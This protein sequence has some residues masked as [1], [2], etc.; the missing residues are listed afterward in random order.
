MLPQHFTY[1]NGDRLS[2][3]SYVRP[4]YKFNEWISA[5]GV[6]YRDRAYASMMT[7]IDGAIVRLYADWVKA[8]Y[9][10]VYNSNGATSGVMPDKVATY[11][12]VVQLDP[13]RYSKDGYIFD[14]WSRS[15]DSILEYQ[16]EG[17]IGLKNEAYEN[18]FNLYARW[19]A[20]NSVVARLILHGERGTF[21]GASV[22]TY[23]LIN[24]QEINIEEPVYA[25]HRLTGWHLMGQAANTYTIP[26][27]CNFTG[28]IE[29]YADWEEENYEVIYHS[30]DGTNRVSTESGFTYDS[31]I[32]VKYATDSS[33]NWSR[34][35]YRFNG[36]DKEDRGSLIKLNANQEYTIEE[37]V[38]LIGVDSR[39]RIHLYASWENKEVVIHFNS[40]GG[41]GTMA[42]Q[43][44]RYGTR[45]P[46]SSN[47]FVRPGYAFSGWATGSNLNYRYLGTSLVEEVIE[48]AGDRDEVTLFAVW[49]PNADKV[50]LTYDYRGGH[51]GIATISYIEV[52]SGSRFVKVLAE[53]EGYTQGEYVNIAGT[54]FIDNVTIINRATTAFATWAEKRYW[55]RYNGRG[56]TPSD[57]MVVDEASYS[58]FDI[59]T[60]PA[61]KYNN[62]GYTFDGW[63]KNS[64]GDVKHFDDQET[65]LSRLTEE[66]EL[67]LYARWRGNEYEIHYDKVRADA[68]GVGDLNNTRFIYGKVATLSSGHYEAPG[69]TQVGW[70]YT[71]NEGKVYTYSL[72]TKIEDTTVFDMPLDYEHSIKIATLTAIY[73]ANPYKAYLHANGGA[74]ADGATDKEVDINYGSSTRD[75][76]IPKRVGYKFNYYDVENAGVSSG[77][78]HD[79][80][81]YTGSRDLVASWS[82]ISYEVEFNPNGGVGVVSTQS[83]TYGSGVRLNRNVF[84]KNGYR[85][86]GWLRDDGSIV[87]NGVDG[88]RLT[89]IDGDRV[90]LRANWEP[91]TY[92]IVYNGNGATSGTMADKLA[93]YNEVTELDPNRY[94]KVGYAFNGWSR[95]TDGVLA[96]VDGGSIG[97][98]NEAYENPF[99][100]YARWISSNSIV[101][102]I[103][104]HGNGG[105]ISGRDIATISYAWGDET[106]RSSKS[107]LQVCRL[108]RGKYNRTSI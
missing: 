92:T 18:P 31:D 49:A 9:S 25:G 87:G 107:R 32:T 6:R 5:D 76:E 99:N 62:A 89:V 13:N 4:G 34:L 57:A 35:G 11:G 56:G 7:E 38:R 86:A 41:L 80:W 100:L 103:I 36:W 94:N 79:I 68:V 20:S 101:G 22:A 53:R 95:A 42:D 75:L 14:G 30:N 46:I 45:V 71:D 63:S 85:F 44:A 108:C 74:Y 59:V 12:E 39:N 27:V 97:L 10:I 1:G 29:I 67:I 51:V 93:T 69:V 90:I 88:S 24:G 70:K 83:F 91:L 21:R 26:R 58:Y 47:L 17:Y 43:V 19:L 2:T 48:D 82:G 102:R 28:N 77:A 37:L 52:A 23:N 40:N 72:G 105:L 78:L 64:N 60:L 65:G 98:N 54:R 50:T 8:T 104:I 61:N 3:N 106:T 66:N 16:D 55:I 15:T 96:Y 84:T 33:M 73:Q 81:D